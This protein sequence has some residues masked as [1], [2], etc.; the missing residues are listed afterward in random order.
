MFW[1]TFSEIPVTNE[2]VVFGKKWLGWKVGECEGRAVQK[3]A[4]HQSRQ[5]QVDDEH[6]PTLAPH[7]LLQTSRV[8]TVSR[9]SYFVQLKTPI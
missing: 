2:M 8:R 9:P 3:L 5:R 1:K 6:P 7:L 4:A